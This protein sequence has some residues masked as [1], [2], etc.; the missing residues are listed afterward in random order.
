MTSRLLQ[1]DGARFRRHF[2]TGR[3]NERT[4]FGYAVGISSVFPP[5]PVRYVPS[6]LGGFNLG[7]M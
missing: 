7:A 1:P 3:K 2:T 4:T 5:T 6:H